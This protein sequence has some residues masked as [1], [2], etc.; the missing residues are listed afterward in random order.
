MDKKELA[1]TFFAQ[2]PTMQKL[3]RINQISTPDDFT[4]NGKRAYTAIGICIC[5]IGLQ[6]F[7]FNNAHHRNETAQTQLVAKVSAITQTAPTANKHVE[8]THP[9]IVSISLFILVIGVIIAF[10]PHLLYYELKRLHLAGATQK[11]SSQTTTSRGTTK[12]TT[13]RSGSTRTTA[14]KKTSS[15][16]NKE[17]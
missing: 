4:V 13:R 11:N 3:K 9:I 17:T 12:K 15:R 16:R 7:L 8:E 6:M 2:L 14:A 5:I 1:S 10:Q